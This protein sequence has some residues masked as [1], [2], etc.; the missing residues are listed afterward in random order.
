MNPEWLSN[1]GDPLGPIPMRELLDHCVYYPAAGLDGDPVKYLGKDFQSFVYVDYGVGREPVLTDLP[2]FNGYQLFSHREVL[3]DELIPHGWVPPELQPGD[4]DP[5]RTADF[6]RPPFAI[7]AIYD[8]KAAVSPEHGP[9]RF[10]LLYIGGDGAATYHSLFYSHK[11]A[12]AVVAVIQ[13]GHGF[14]RNWTNFED[15]NQ[16]LARLVRENPAGM[17]DY[18]LYGGWGDGDFYRHAPWPEYQ[19][20]GRVLHGRL[21]LFARRTEEQLAIGNFDEPVPEPV[22]KTVPVP[23]WMSVPGVPTSPIPM[24]ELLDR[25]VYYPAAGLNG[26]PI[27]YLGRYFQSFVYVDNGVEREQV[28]RKLRNFRGYDGFWHRE[29]PLDDLVLEQGPRPEDHAPTFAIWAVFMRNADVCPEHGPEQFSLLYIG[30]GGVAMYYSLFNH[31]RIAPAV[32]A[33]IQPGGGFEGPNNTFATR[34]RLNPPDH[35]LYGGWDDG[36]L[37]QH[38][39]WPEYQTTG[40]ILHKRLRLFARRTDEHLGRGDID[41]PEPK[42]KPDGKVDEFDDE[43]DDL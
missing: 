18:L 33:L 28:L 35:L 21:R 31:R 39:P 37:Y 40:L 1:P 5:T 16:V 2:N 17:P 12:P 7:W 22:A 24:K 38:A 4:G 29:V 11:V 14:G 41:E 43:V 25:C 26:D 32:V 9:E 23:A 34:V 3:Q 27:K 8:R 20:A 30:G 6:I 10:S 15:P 42:P 13:P 19:T 36:D